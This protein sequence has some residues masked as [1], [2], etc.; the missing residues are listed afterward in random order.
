[1]LPIDQEIEQRIRDAAISNA[2]SLN[3]FGLGLTHLPETIGLLSSLHE[4][5][6]SDNQ[7]TVLPEIIGSLS[8]L[9]RLDVSDNQIAALPKSIGQLSRLQRL[10]ASGN[11]LNTLPESIGDLGSLQRLDVSHNQL[12]TL[13]ESIG[14]LS[15]LRVLYASD[16]HL[17][18]LPDSLN[19]LISLEQI[20]LDGNPS[21]AL[22]PEVLRPTGPSD[23]I[24]YY[25]RSRKS[26]PLNEAKLILVGRG[27]VGKTSL[28]SLLVHGT[29]DPN[30]K[31]T[32]GIRITP[33][34]VS[35]G[36]ENVRLNIWDFGGQEIMHATHQFFL[37]Q[38]SL[39][40]LVLNAREGEQDANIEYWLRIIESF[41]AE[42]P[43]LIAINKIKDHPFD[44]NRRGLRAKYPAIRDFVPTDCEA[45]SG[46][47]DLR[48]AIV[49]ETDRLEHLRDPFP[50]EWLRVK[51][52]LSQMQEDYIT[53]DRYRSIC[54]DLGVTTRK[55]QDTL[56]RFLHNMGIIVNFKNDPRLS[57]TNVLNPEWVTN[58]VYKILNAETIV[59]REGVLEMQDLEHILDGN[60]YPR[61]RHI[62][63]TD[64][65]RK[66]E[67]CL[68][69]E[70][71]YERYLV[72][73]L[74]PKEEPPLDEFKVIDSLCFQYHY[75]ILPEGLVP[76]FI[77]RTHHH[78]RGL[79]R[80]RTGVV[81][82]YD[83]NRALVKADVQDSKVFITVTGSPEG[84]RGLLAIVRSHFDHI[85][86][87]IAKLE[88]VEMVPVPEYPD[89]LL[90]YRRLLVREAGGR[91]SVEIEVG[92]HVVEI[93]LSKL[94]DGIEDAA[95]RSRR[96]E[97]AASDQESIRIDVRDSG[98]VVIQ[99]D[100]MEQTG[101]DRIDQ[102]ISD[103]K[104]IQSPVGVQQTINDSYKTI[105]KAEASDLRDA[106]EA[107]LDKVGVLLENVDSRTASKAKRCLETF[108]GE[109][110]AEEP[111]KSLLEV[112]GKGLVEAANNVAS[113][114][115]PIAATV[116]KI[117]SMLPN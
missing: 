42:S 43:V 60:E 66:F 53:Y 35:I 97:I 3:L 110:T 36:S 93:S 106:L 78:N 46:L 102:T 61:D 56:A 100:V 44:L 86:A 54:E 17:S 34:E 1:M 2:T 10:D 11:H 81:L 107:L 77:V 108:I 45:R 28:V 89:V 30:E 4:L 112:T 75:N 88:A 50:A 73:E 24:E 64:L 6:I 40:L 59:T 95:S 5:Y 23:I 79:P 103:S 9:R 85:H 67:L 115:G 55:S 57:E 68:P 27:G 92:E 116:A 90:E 39:Y 117:I 98:T 49:L 29:Y 52:W 74:L 87:S 33:W 91:S 31:K 37:T 58:G 15:Q 63:I 101:G 13:P 84:R 82:E 7:L 25:F 76:R 51:D 20:H 71:N 38:R 47:E 16:N 26:R 114:A 104:F 14:Q 8:S 18:S 12:A 48:K 41:G 80:W 94:L 111:Q 19:D 65:M 105:Q 83:G 69:F 32:D 62:F 109:A 96:L 70:G 72:P 99:G 113:V 22:P 21:L